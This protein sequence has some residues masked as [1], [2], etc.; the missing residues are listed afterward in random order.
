MKIGISSPAF[1]YEPFSKTLPAVAEEFTLWELVADLKQLLPQIADEFKQL[2]PSYNIEFSAHAP[3][4]D[5]NFA[6]LN[7]ELRKLA[8]NYITDTI[9]IAHEL[10]ITKISFHPGHLSPSGVYY[11]DK[12]KET[13]LKSIHEIANFAEDYSITLALE[14]MPIKNWTLGNSA[15]EI[16]EMISGTSIGI[17]FDIGHA[18]IQNEVDE[19]LKN[20]D[21]IYNVHFHDNNGRRDEHLV[22]GEGA[23]DIPNIIKK[24]NNGYTGNII[25][26]SNNLHEG[27]K[28]KEYLEKLFKEFG[29]K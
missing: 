27:V 26:E 25:I 18:F 2:T 23:I 5:L 20:I 19:F 15:N 10:E 28:S 29:I 11:I 3:F 14:N 12:V 24:L 1:A 13:N 21:L 4:N 6:A 9:K 22:L 17:C 7:P 16:L 8:I